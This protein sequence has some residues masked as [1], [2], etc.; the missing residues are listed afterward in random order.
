[1]QQTLRWFG[2][3]M[4]WLEALPH[5]S[6]RAVT[7]G[8]LLLGLLGGGWLLAAQLPGMASLSSLPGLG[9]DRLQG[10][11]AVLSG[12]TLRVGGR[13]VRLSGIDAPELDQ[14]CGGNHRGRRW[15]CG[16]AAQNALDALARGRTVLCNIAGSDD[17]GHPLAI[18]HLGDKDLAAEM[19]RRGH[20]FAGA[21]LFSSYRRLEAEARSA[22]RGVWRTALVERPAD[23]RARTWEAAKR[24]APDGCPIK[25]HVT[26]D[27]RIYV[28]PWSRDYARLRVRE[29]RGERWF[30]SEREARA[31]GWRPVERT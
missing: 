20:A 27:G 7:T 17:S 26:A 28:L 13:A 29:Q 10:R 3:R 6:P 9:G 21:G 30:C 11:A 15:R 19:V 16:V 24:S 1:V 18:C 31:A 5:P 14:N 2:R 22:K 25:G 23:Y 12:D 4:P 8:L